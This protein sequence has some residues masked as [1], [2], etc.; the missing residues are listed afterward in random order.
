[1]TTRVPRDLPPVP[2][3][4]RHY[5]GK[6]YVGALAL[7]H[8]DLAAHLGGQQMSHVAEMIFGDTEATTGTYRFLVHAGLNTRAICL[9]I[10]PYGFVGSGDYG[11]IVVTGAEGEGTRRIRSEASTIADLTEVAHP[12]LCRFIVPVT[13][14][15]L[16]EI[17]FTTTD[18]QLHS[19]TAWEIPRAELLGT[20]VHV[21]RSMASAA[22]YITDNNTGSNKRGVREL[23]N[24]PRKLR[25]IGNRHLLNM[26]FNQNVLT[27][28]AGPTYILGSA[29]AAD[30][31]R[32]VCRD[33]SG[34]TSTTTPVRAKIR[35]DSIGAG[36]WTAVYILPGGTNCTIVGINATGWWPR[37]GGALVDPGALGSAAFADRVKVTVERTAG[38]GSLGINGF[39]LREAL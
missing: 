14:G 7:A 38:A 5:I 24:L 15:A 1:M 10:V 20:E 6:P 4:A 2:S 28:A 37:G 36:T 29:A 39:W 25:T 23:V 21:D 35:V 8:V 12:E 9:L 22:L 32:I 3:T 18:V 11:T 33:V 13:A 27:A 34:G 26:A 19:L 17:T 31:P 30:G 16:N